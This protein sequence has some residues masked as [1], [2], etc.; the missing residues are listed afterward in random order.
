MNKQVTKSVSTPHLG[1]ASDI[2]V[3]PRSEVD[4]MN[5]I[6][7]PRAP[8]PQPAPLSRQDSSDS[9]P[10]P[11]L[12]QE[13]SLLSTKLINAINHSTSLD[14]N[15]QQTRHELDSTKDRL[16]KLE[17]QNKEYEEWIATGQ[18]V[19][20]EVFAK[21]EKQMISE[22]QEERNRRAEAEKAKR[23]V[24][25]EVENL[26]SALF[27]EAN[28]VRIIQGLPFPS[29]RCANYSR[30]WRLLVRK[31]KRVRRKTIN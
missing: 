31:R 10:H 26:T 12:S 18:L 24:D 15:L 29:V 16:A 20:K 3:I 19:E 2:A 4:G 6:P 13:V 30:W 21:M 5:T 1:M 25:S 8:T 17:A 14:D 9:S 23:K 27:E 7:D 28:K 22:L 11:D